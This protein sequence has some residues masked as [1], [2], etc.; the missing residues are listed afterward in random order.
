MYRFER[1]L[2][3]VLILCLIPAGLHAQDDTE[4]GCPV[5]V[6]TALEA[7]DT[8]CRDLERNSACYGNVFIQT[9]AR[10]G[11]TDLDFDTVG[12]IV[13]L[14]NIQSLTL[15]EMNVATNQWGVAL[16]RVQANLPDTVP[17]QNV[18]ILLF[19]DVEISEAPGS[20]NPMQSFYFRSGIG[21]A[22]CI[23]APESGILIQTPEGV[24][25]ITM[26]VNGVDLQIGSTAY[27]QAFS[28]DEEEGTDGQMIINLLEG[29]ATIS[30][31]D[32]QATVPAGQ[33]STVALDEDLQPTGIPADPMPY[34]ASAFTALPLS[35]LEREI[36]VQQVD[37]EQSVASDVTL[38]SG[39]WLYSTG[40]LLF[41]TDCPA[42]L[43]AYMPQ[44]MPQVSETEIIDWTG[45]FTVDNYIQQ[46]E[47]DGETLPASASIS[48]PEAG[49]ILIEYAED[50][51]SIIIETRVISERLLETSMTMS[52]TEGMSCTITIP[53][54]VEYQE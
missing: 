44:V 23:E 34:D 19:G 37:T 20:P 48:S 6:E 46:I 14:S 1:V 12:D 2:L 33:F 51:A 32:G 54:T 35:L 49:V 28:P 10:P 9:E 26:N 41:S 11:V 29:E 43:V 30:V 42:E 3:V 5:I 53:G 17:G 45:G 16:L 8:A 15:N 40:E 52:I 25:E 4:A 36:E 22:P 31:N 21:E 47:R 7:A 39:T 13:N 24:S 38:L 27:L 18:T 50:G